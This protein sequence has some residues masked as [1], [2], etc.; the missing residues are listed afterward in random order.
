MRSLLTSLL[1]GA[2]LRAFGA[3]VLKPDEDVI[4]L[5]TIAIPQADGSWQV[6]IHGWVFEPERDSIKR[7]A[8]LAIIAKTIGLGDETAAELEQ[9][10]LFKDRVRPFLVDNEG[11]KRLVVS[12][13]GQQV[14]MDPSGKDGHCFASLTLDADAVSRHR[15]PLGTLPYT[16]GPQPGDPRVFHGA[17]HLI[18]HLGISVI[19][20]LDDTIKITG[21]RDR[22]ETLRKT[23]L[24]PFA[25]VPGMV[26]WYRDWAAKGVRFHVVSASPWQLYPHLDPFMRDAGFPPVT[27]HL[28]T[29]RWTKSGLAELT[30]PPEEHKNAE[31]PAILTAF[32]QRRFV[33]VGDS[34]QQDP[35][36]YGALARAHANV[37]LVLIRDITGDA[38]DGERYRQ[39]FQDV[40]AEKWSLF[41]DPGA[42]VDRLPR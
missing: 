30:A 4:F 6:R 35:E 7:R 31:I 34:G 17:V 29:V 37:A 19:S 41:T 22:R 8:L 5:P 33:L 1:L 15:T 23:F 32:P 27:W 38:P 28:K 10:N 21:C 11:G 3:E 9:R 12:I 16:C 25:A 14:A 39:A 2:V 20:D 13:A 18:D 36:V 24:E 26:A 42:M 40:P